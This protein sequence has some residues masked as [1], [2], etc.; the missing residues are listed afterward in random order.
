MMCYRY[1]ISLIRLSRLCNQYFKRNDKGNLQTT[2]IDSNATTKRKLELV[3]LSAHNRV[4]HY[5]GM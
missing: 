5:E 1:I 2:E 4:Y 3:I